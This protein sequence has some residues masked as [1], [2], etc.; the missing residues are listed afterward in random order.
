M[1]RVERGL[2]T[3]PVAPPPGTG[4][5]EGLVMVRRPLDTLSFRPKHLKRLSVLQGNSGGD[6]TGRSDAAEGVNIAVDIAEA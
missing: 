5:P 6:C 4:F 2:P 1:T 3:R